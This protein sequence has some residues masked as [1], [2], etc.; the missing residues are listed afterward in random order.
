[1]GAA[2]LGGCVVVQLWEEADP[3]GVLASPRFWQHL[4]AKRVLLFTTGS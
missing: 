2:L 4:N 3:A 1:M